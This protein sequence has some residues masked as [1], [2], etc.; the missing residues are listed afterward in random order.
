VLCEE[1]ERLL[2][3]LRARPTERADIEAKASRSDFPTEGWQTI[4][5][6]ANSSGG[7]FLLGVRD[8]TFEAVGVADPDRVQTHLTNVCADELSVPVRPDILVCQ[9]DGV[10]V[11]AARIPS[12]RREERPVFK[13]SK[14]LPGGAYLRIGNTDRQMTMAEVRRMLLQQRDDLDSRPVY[15]AS[16]DDLDTALAKA[17]PGSRRPQDLQPSVKEMLTGLG[18]LVEEE[19]VACP[20]LAG[21]LFFS[22]EPQR[23]YPNL[24]ITFT[25]Y[26]GTDVGEST[27]GGVFFLDNRD[28]VGPVPRMIRDAVAVVTGR[29]AQRS[30][31]E[32]LLHRDIA[33]YPA[34]ALREAIV[35]A[36]AHRD[37]SMPGTEIQIRLFSDR[38]E[39]QSPGQ[40]LV[41]IE[42]LTTGRATRNPVLMRLLREAGFVEERGIGIDR[43]IA[44]MARADMEPPAFDHVGESF[45]VTMKNHSLLSAESL[46]WLRGFAGYELNDRQ[47]KALVVM[48]HGQEVT[49]A[50]YRA[51]NFVDR[52][53]A[54][55]ELTALRDLGLAEQV[56]ERRAARYVLPEALALGAGHDERVAAVVAALGPELGRLYSELLFRQRARVGDLIRALGASRPTLVNRLKVL[57]A[58][59]LAERKAAG[60]Q[61]PTAYYVPK[62]TEG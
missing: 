17:H 47:R 9:I 55:H 61:D 14:G 58:N 25:Q 51:L 10:T 12:A 56:G 20:T 11:I 26:A 4:T 44:A 7:M 19:G 41:P 15:A 23:W 62:L 46:E 39:I 53:L 35:N 5:A 59:G 27:R 30:V 42:E 57:V 60:P 50:A 29:M 6:F 18:A 16:L 43:M 22:R 33:E 31:Q 49:N 21:L 38:L 36:V 40:S 8:A 54:T 45:Q 37:Y 52:S 24:K 3:E 2:Q 32:G 13:R 28:I 1:V 34:D 48:R